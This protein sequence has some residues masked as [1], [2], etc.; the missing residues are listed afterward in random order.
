MLYI[1]LDDV[2]I[3]KEWVKRKEVEPFEFHPPWAFTV[4]LQTMNELLVR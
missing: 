4:T 2:K 1:S 3:E